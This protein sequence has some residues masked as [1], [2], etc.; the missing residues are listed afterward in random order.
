MGFKTICVKTTL[1][2][3]L[4]EQPFPCILLWGQ[5]HFIVLH[6]ITKT[7]N[8][9]DIFNIAD[10][11]FGLIKINKEKFFEMWLTTNEKGI[12][13]FLQP[14]ANFSELQIPLTQTKS[15][16]KSWAFIKKYLQP[17]KKYLMLIALFLAITTVITWIFPTMIQKMIDKG[18]NTKNSNIIW[19]VLFSQAALIVGQVLSEW[20]RNLF[21]VKLSMKLST[22]IILDFVQKLVSLPIRFFDFKTHSDIIQR[23][24]DHSRIESFLNKYNNSKCFSINNIYNIFNLIT[25]L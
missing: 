24:E 6:K 22:K 11:A 20:F 17:H 15:F 9:V 2:Y 23:I 13:L 14:T 16:S 10:P 5:N 25:L 3:L 8:G 7:K 12:A 1:N 19:I 4:E 21:S 18:I